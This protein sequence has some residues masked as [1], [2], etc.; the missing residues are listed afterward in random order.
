FESTTI[1]YFGYAQ[2]S[3]ASDSLKWWSGD[4]P[5][6]VSGTFLRS[7]NSRRQGVSKLPGKSKR[8]VGR[9]GPFNFRCLVNP[10][11]NSFHRKNKGILC[12]TTLRFLDDVLVDMWQ[13]FVAH[14]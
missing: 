11:R 9:S 3:A 13:Q 14:S 7:P 6:Y 4:T 8:T 10:L 12:N 1:C 2:Y 5:D